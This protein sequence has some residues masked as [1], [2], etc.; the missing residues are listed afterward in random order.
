MAR[1]S[2]FTQEQAEK[3]CDWLSCGGSL[4]EFTKQ[5]GTPDEKTVYRWLAS[6]EQFR[7]KYAHARNLHAE[8]EAERIVEI[9]DDLDIPP[10]HKRYMIDARKWTASKLL[11]KKYGDKLDITSDGKAIKGYEVIDPSKT[12]FS[13]E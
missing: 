1:P 5:E 10:E 8:R 4:V 12:V 2:S 7:Q 13:G 9:A 11:P 3:I 6:N